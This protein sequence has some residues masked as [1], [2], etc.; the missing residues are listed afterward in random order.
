G[1]I[2][3]SA[4][5]V[6]MHGSITAEVTVTNTGGREGTETVFWFIRDP[7]A[8][9]TR[10]LRELKFFEQASLA[11]DASRTFR[12]AI[13][14]LRDLSF[15]DHQGRRVLQTGEIILMAGDQAVTFSVIP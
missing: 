11:P 14:P 5:Q 10:P 13:D 1:P 9:V 7:A 12:F 15:P 8:S 4:P 3:L 6:G 2:R